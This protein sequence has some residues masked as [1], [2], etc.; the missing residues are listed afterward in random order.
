[1][2]NKKCDETK[3]NKS[4]VLQHNC[5]TISTIVDIVKLNKK[6][7]TCNCFFIIIKRDRKIKLFFCLFLLLIFFFI[8]ISF[9]ITFMAMVLDK[10]VFKL[11]VK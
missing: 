10:T 7:L 6:Y 9:S 5:I 8:S 2:R 11:H 1:M 4:N 3:V